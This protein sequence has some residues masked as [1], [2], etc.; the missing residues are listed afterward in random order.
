MSPKYLIIGLGL[1]M[2][3][4]GCGGGG[5][6]GNG[7]DGSVPTNTISSVKVDGTLDEASTVTA[8]GYDIGGASLA[9]VVD[10]DTTV[11]TAFNATL[12]AD[13][14]SLHADTAGED[15]DFDVN[16][17]AGTTGTTM[18]NIEPSR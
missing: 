7:G 17:A 2:V 14:T 9:P 4:A 12:V 6:G 11:D 15:F 18:I 16:M 13:G 3:L 5:S 8:Q 10:A 1:S